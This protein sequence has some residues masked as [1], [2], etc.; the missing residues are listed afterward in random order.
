MDDGNTADH[1]IQGEDTPAP[2][3]PEESE[4]ADAAET[5]PHE[6]PT[7]ETFLTWLAK[8]KPASLLTLLRDPDFALV[9]VTAFA[10]FRVN[11]AGYANPLV[12]RRLAQEA[13]RDKKFAEKLQSLAEIPHPALVGHPSPPGSGEG[14]VTATQ[15]P[16]SEGSEGE[17]ILASS[18]AKTAMSGSQRPLST[19][20]GGGVPDEGGVGAA[21]RLRGE[22][23]QRRRERDEA[24][25]ARGVAE[26]ARSEAERRQ[27]QAEAE[28]DEARQQAQKQAQR[29]TRLER[30][31]GKL[32]IERTS[33]LRAL[34]QRETDTESVPAST[35]TAAATAAEAIRS[36]GP[37]LWQTAVAHLLDKR[38]Y[39]LALSLAD[40][41]LRTD[42]E[43]TTAL[44]IAAQALAAKG[45]TREAVTLLRRRLGTALAQGDRAEAADILVR[46]L[47][48]IPGDGE[49]DLRAF[50][51]GI[52]PDDTRTIE[53][54]RTMLARLRVL[55]PEAHAS[56]ATLI[57]QS[58]PAVLAEALMPAPGQIGLDDPLPLGLPGTVSARRLIE[59]VDVGNI[60]L[61][62]GARA[63]LTRLS[64]TD[65]PTLERVQQALERAA[66]DDPSSLVPL[67][68]GRE[69][70]PV[71]VDGSNAAWF[72]QESLVT[73]RPRLRPLLGL[74][75]ALRMRGYFPVLLYADAPLPYTVD[76]PETL[77]TMTARGEIS[78]VD[79]GVDADEVLLREAKRFGAPLVTND[80][81]TDWDPDN[82]V[83]KIRFT[84]SLTGEAYLMSE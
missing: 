83:P 11:A 33:L 47:P 26:A 55:A 63:A 19:S 84:L 57:K 31:V 9:S 73:G 71:I 4:L 30:Q 65:T 36:A 75:R 51:T 38:R 82:E 42:P 74:R 37:D 41:V 72:D 45:N 1:L 78:L 76:E 22:R 20:G 15:V 12:R 39:D 46:L 7:L 2:A 10:G 21:E 79:S 5:P 29:I 25:Q 40:D 70:G 18:I 81:M 6:P 16:L 58:A 60:G 14:P 77:R 48:L 44:D 27:Q 67:L 59:A 13:V 3:A 17:R 68:G 69:R 64:R 53:Q 8:I 54:A 52:R 80:Y 43:E 28:R 34:K 62:E 50:F 23:N 49:R 56:A 66:G 35:E 24:R 61:V 32:Q